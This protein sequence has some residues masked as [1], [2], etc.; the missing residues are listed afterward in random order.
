VKSKEITQR[1][2]QA[3]AVDGLL[4]LFLLVRRVLM[5]SPTGSGKTVA[6]AAYVR[7][8]KHKRVLWIAHRVELLRQARAEL[9]AA[10]VPA[11]DIGILSGVEKS[12]TKAR[13]LLASVDM[14]RGR[15]VAALNPSLI[16]VDE[17]HRVAAQSYQDIID[18]APKAK[19]I[20][21]TA[22]P[23]RLDGKSLKDSFDDL[24][25]MAGMGELIGLGHIAAPITYAL[26]LAK[27][28]AIVS[29][30]KSS[31]GDYAQGELGRRLSTK[32]L[33]GD[34]VSNHQRLAKGWPTLLFAASRK[35]GQVLRARFRASGVSTGY[36]D[37]DS[38]P[39]E[40][41]KA[42]AELR[43]G[44]IEVLVN[45]DVLSEGFD[46]PPV[47]CIVLA[48][49]TKSLTRYLQQC[50]RA[51]RPYKGRRPIMLDHAGNCWRF[52]LPNIE[53]DW[54]LDSDAKRETTGDAPIKQCPECEAIISASCRTCPECGAELPIKEQEREVLEAELK[55]VKL[56]AAHVEK[57]RVKLKEFAEANKLSGAWVEET[58]RMAS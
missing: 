14:F 28:R 20:G 52:D 54:S 13:Y 15:P 44:A 33:V 47:K 48:R 41:K 32:A 2:Y 26:P 55:R 57:L 3:R 27:A 16:V 39:S 34:I 30:L 6:A 4:Q 22:T 29:G 5:V 49:P 43:S 1:A 17:A 10:G 18:A 51:S 58:I 50:G 19:V 31:R 23:W 7:A 21:L 46:C 53:R 35:H 12:N 24:I 8:S 25:V 37:G 36:V 42:L 40:R 56:A 11:K 45:V 9:I 38:L